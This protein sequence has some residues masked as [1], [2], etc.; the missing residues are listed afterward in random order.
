MY[1]LWKVST[2]IYKCSGNISHSSYFTKC[3]SNIAAMWHYQS[4]YLLLCSHFRAHT[5]NLA[6][7]YDLDYAWPMRAKLVTLEKVLPRSFKYLAKSMPIRPG[8][9]LTFF[10]MWP[11]HSLFWFHLMRW[12][13]ISTLKVRWIS[14]DGRAGRLKL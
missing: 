13:R 3:S 4:I 9:I 1:E 11:G 7:N 12:S 14:V 8:Q 10:E 5:F 6:V 2:A